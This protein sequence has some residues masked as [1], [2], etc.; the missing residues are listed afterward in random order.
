[1]AVVVALAH[2]VND[3]YAAFLSPLLPRIMDKLGLSITLA[4]ALAMILSLAASLPQP[5]VGYLSDRYGRRVF[6]VLGPIISAVFLSLIGVPPSFWVLVT[7]LLLGGLGSSVFHPP[8]ASM[9]ARISE[10][11]GSGVRMSVF[12]LGGSLG[13]AIGPLVAVGIVGWLGLERLWIAMF[14]GIIVAAFVFPFLPPSRRDRAAKLPPSPTVVLKTLRGPLGLLFGI[15]MMGAFAQRVFLTMAPIIG[16][17]S[18]ASETSG[19]LALSLYLG[20]Q[21]LGTLAGGFLADRMDRGRL[22]AG[23]TFFAFPA[24]L[25]AVSLTPAALPA[26]LAACTAG[27]F[28]MAMMPSIVVKAQEILPDSAAVGSGIVMGLAWGA[29]SI[30]VLGTGALADLIGTRE[31]AMASM[32]ALLIGTALALHPLLREKSRV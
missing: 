7:V 15:S 16:N 12:S 20:T 18:G 17:E 8:A 29:G 25:L 3:S 14:P 10:G 2:G 30:C 11:K 5:F 31:A 28:G 4:A 1:V 32:P 23:L 13:F 22:L 26:Y 24:H 27:F 21:A 9:A 19:A 6:I